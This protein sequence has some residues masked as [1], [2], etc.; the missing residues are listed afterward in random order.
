MDS[1]DEM[2][3]PTN[4]ASIGP[5]ATNRNDTYPFITPTGSELAGKSV[6]ITGAS[7]GIGRV[8]AIRCAKAGASKIAI[9][10]RSP[11]DAV[12][13]EIKAEANKTGHSPEVIAL[14]M[15]VTSNDSV[16][17][18]AE[19]VKKAF[20]NSLDIL[21]NNAG[22]LPKWV[23]MVDSD[24]IEWW[25]G[26]EVNINGTYLCTRYFLPLLFNGSGRTIINMSSISAHMITY[27]ASSYQTS[28]IAV[29]RF[30][31]FIAR[32]Y[33]K[34]GI[35]AMALHP[36]GIKTDMAIS[37]PEMVHSYL[38]DEPELAA[39]TVIWLTRERR[40]WLNSRFINCP[41]DMEELEKRKEEIVE[42]DLLKFRLTI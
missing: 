38:I 24:P 29:C 8:L 15:D 5:F 35:I 10:A 36:G 22:F 28:K 1:R 41:W 16:R 21:V 11:L 34:Q 27:G 7:K 9:S 31:E 37:M 40:D 26:W 19:E 23:P 4:W 17:E 6:L 33:E 25:Q 18:A 30:T 32:E 3:R 12:V 39:D 42:R 14:N 2:T 20:N 13:A